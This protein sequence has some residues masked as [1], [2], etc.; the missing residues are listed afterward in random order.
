MAR[1]RLIFAVALLCATQAAPTVVAHADSLATDA[2]QELAERYSP[3]VMVQTQPSACSTDG[4]AFEPMSVD[5]LLGNGQIALRQMG[6]GDPVLKWGPTANDLFGLGEGFYLDFPG[7]RARPGMPVR[8]GLPSLHRRSQPTVYAAGG[9]ARRSARSARTAVLVLLVLQRLEQQARER[10]GVIQLVFPAGSAEQALSVAPI[11]VGYAQHESG[12]RQSWSASILHRDGDHPVVYPSTGSHASYFD[13]ALHIGRSAGEGFGC[14]DSTGPSTELRPDVVVLPDEAPAATDAFA[15][16][17]FDGRWGERH[18]GPYNGPTG[19]TTKDRWTRPIEWQD[20]LRTTSV[21]VP[22]V[23]TR[24]GAVADA[25]CSVVE[26]GSNL[27]LKFAQSPLSI[28]IALF[29]VFVFVRFL[30]RRTVWNRTPTSPIISRRRSGQILRTSARM[31]AQAKG[32]FTMIGVVA[33]PVALIGTLLAALVKELP[34]VQDF[35]DLTGSS[36]LTGLIMA[37]LVTAVATRVG[38]HI[39]RCRGVVNDVRHRCRSGAVVDAFRQ[40]RIGQMAAAPHWFRSGCRARH[41]PWLHDRARPGRS[42]HARTTGLHPSGDHARRR[43][44]SARCHRPQH[45][46]GTAP[47]VQHRRDHRSDDRRDEGRLHDD[48]IAGPDRC[49]ATVLAAL[50]DDRRGRSA[51]LAPISAIHGDVPLRKRPSAG[52][53]PCWSRPTKRT[54]TGEP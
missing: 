9:R 8:A 6:S 54:T 52:R 21:V 26:S 20:S 53:R 11:S 47:M 22:A 17:A 15:W 42:V 37:L 3:V 46:C 35:F 12:E 23:G 45:R 30:A 24:S 19:P 32:T 34:I 1:S 33:I 40:I 44:N 5:A 41:H 36:G 27:V 14:D 48:R 16:L 43:R 4:E 18:G 50:V 49:P 29:L 2:E 25:F 10:L 7:D 31:L 38:L 28:V 51:V 39:C 13:S